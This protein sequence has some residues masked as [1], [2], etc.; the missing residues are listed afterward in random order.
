MSVS[1]CVCVSVC[2]CLSVSVCVSVC[3]YLCL[4]ETVCVLSVSMMRRV[5]R[6]EGDR[7]K[8]GTDLVR[9]AGFHDGGH[10]GPERGER[11]GSKEERGREGEKKLGITSPWIFAAFVFGERREDQAFGREGGADDE[12]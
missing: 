9:K 10:G 4:S 1:V 3:V 8:Y 5:A 11:L 2:L 12:A 7:R 6:R